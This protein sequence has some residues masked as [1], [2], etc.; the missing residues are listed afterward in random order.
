VV[1]LFY[2]TCLKEVELVI[3]PDIGVGNTSASL[4]NL[5]LA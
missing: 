4:E 3:V 2:L 5:H 1:L